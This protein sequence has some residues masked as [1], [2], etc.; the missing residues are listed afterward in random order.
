MASSVPQ[1]VLAHYHDLSER[2]QRPHGSGLINHTFFVEG[3]AEPAIVQRLHRVFAG[4]V[5]EDIEAVTGH[6]TKK[7]IV[8][9]RVLRTNSQKLWVEDE[10]GRAW[11]A[12]SF[13][14]GES[15]DTVS[16]PALAREAGK[17]VASFHIAVADLDY[18]YKHVRQGVHD[19]HKHLATL[20]RA[21]EENPTHRLY[22]EVA[23]LGEK[24]FR[25][26]EGLPD[27]STF[28][29]RNAHGDLKI[30]N[31]LFRE[32]RGVCLVDL[33]TLSRM[34]WPHEMG[35]A[36]RSWCNPAGEDAANVRVDVETFRAALSGYGEVVRGKPFLTSSEVSA[37]V[38]GL[39]TI[40]LELSSRF[41]A[42][43][44]YER[45]FGYDERRFPA[46]GEHNLLRGRGQFALLES[47][48][49]SRG[50][51]EGVVKDT[52]L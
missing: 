5:N 48:L 32:G 42:D 22:A 7:G 44:L 24:V 12:L 15:F 20:K 41:L 1:S 35:D 34:K 43:A 2:P 4:I 31:L 13:V 33:D 3:R 40:C 47:V 9:P 51:L 29:D 17:L 45:Y 52:L 49:S 6:L 14:Q 10:E 38:S 21:I 36:L 23:A 37:L 19:T 26:A 46:R 8:T 39:A 27:L 11:R 18:N 50:A 16:S 25:Y 30:S 28:P